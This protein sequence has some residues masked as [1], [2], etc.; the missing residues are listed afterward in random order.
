M[1][2]VD[3]KGININI[4]L[5]SLQI[6]STTVFLKVGVQKLEKVQ[7]ISFLAEKI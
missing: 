2:V 6:N 7:L 3:W 1:A 5:N 4:K